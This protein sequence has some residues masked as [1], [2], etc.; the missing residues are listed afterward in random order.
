VT[1]P[2][3][4][5]PPPREGAEAGYYPDPL[6]SGRGRWWDGAQWTPTVGP[7]YEEPAAPNQ[8]LPP[9]EKVCKRCGVRSATFAG[10]C[11]NCGR[12]Y[13]GL[14]PLQIVGISAAVVLFT[15][16]GCAACVAVS[17]WDLNDNSISQAEFD[18]ISNGMPR[19]EVE[20]RLGDPY[21]EYESD[22]VECISY[23]E[24]GDSLF[25]DEYDFCFD[26][27]GRLAV[28]GSE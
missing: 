14:T 4:E 11:P 25:G 21:I 6:G 1:T 7:R 2:V 22:G 20:R 26:S 28:K 27:A 15:L 19:A 5:L 17:I 3:E 13:T 8:L 10:N 16:G 23:N 12:S 9:P 24:E 18:A